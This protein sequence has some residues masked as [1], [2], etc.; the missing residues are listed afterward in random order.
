ML[1]RS[2]CAWH[3]AISGILLGCFSG[4][5]QLFLMPFF[6]IHDR[7]IPAECDKLEERKVVVV[8][9]TGD[10]LLYNDPDLTADL[11][12][13]IGHLL[14]EHGRKIT[15]ISH[16]EVANWIDENQD[17]WSDFKEV[18]E[19]V[20]A[21]MVVGIDLG[22]FSLY[23]G[24]TLY[25]GHADVRVTVYDVTDEG[26]VVYQPEVPVI[27]FPPNAPVESSVKSK[28]AFRRQFIG[29]IA[30]NLARHF[31]AHDPTANFASDSTV[32]RR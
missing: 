5:P 21:D 32:L 31:Y 12:R 26:E 29:V 9:R 7:N 22:T 25:Q 13:R 19:G 2:R 20:G 23:R 24:Q 11:S 30:E 16:D 28:T 14:R 18:G 27:V 8:C 15:V 10:L 6:L 4:C 17:N 3:I 1:V